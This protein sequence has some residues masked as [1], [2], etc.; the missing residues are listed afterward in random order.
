[1]TELKDDIE[2]EDRK[3][4]WI[5]FLYNLQEKDLKWIS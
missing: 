4:Y 2:V 5:E 3:G 1:M